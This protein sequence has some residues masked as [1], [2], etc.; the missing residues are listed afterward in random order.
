[1][2]DVDAFRFRL[3][4]RFGP[5]PPETQECF[6]SFPSVAWR[7][8]LGVEKVFLKGGRMTLFFVSNADRSVLSE[9]GVWQ[10]DRLHD[11]IYPAL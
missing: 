3:E 11:E 5:V 10:N 4:D 9:S 2:K 6:A 1:M 7:R 8:G